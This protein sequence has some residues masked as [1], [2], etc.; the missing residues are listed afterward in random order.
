MVEHVIAEGTEL[1]G[2]ALPD[3]LVR[4]AADGMR[5]IAAEDVAQGAGGACGRELVRRRGGRLR[6]WSA[7]AE[8]DG[9]DD[10]E[11]DGEDDERAPIGTTHARI[12][13]LGSRRA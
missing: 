12:V 9:G 1:R 8:D 6:R 4:R 3:G 13:N 5:D 2:E 10:G 11:K 7:R